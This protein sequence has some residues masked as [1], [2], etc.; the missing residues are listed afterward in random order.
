M[1]PIVPNFPQQRA[2]RRPRSMMIRANSQSRSL[3]NKSGRQPPIRDAAALP[4][5]RQR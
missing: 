1:P 4:V 2:G 3:C 5:A